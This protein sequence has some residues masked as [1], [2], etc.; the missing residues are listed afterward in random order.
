MSEDD[1]WQMYRS[2]LDACL[3]SS[4]PCVPYLG[5][6]LTQVCHQLSYNKMKA[7]KKEVEVKRRSNSFDNLSSLAES[8]EKLLRKRS[9]LFQHDS[10]QVEGGKRA[11]TVSISAPTSPLASDDEEEEESA[12]RCGVRI[13]QMKGG[14]DDQGRLGFSCSVEDTA[15]ESPSKHRFVQH[16]KNVDTSESSIDSKSSFRDKRARQG[17]KLQSTP[18]KDINGYIL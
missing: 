18:I 10:L 1:N 12:N 7:E 6:F 9:S 4:T 14:L 15:T 3:A 16:H 11:S 5:Q 2:E 17:R 13:P 8:K